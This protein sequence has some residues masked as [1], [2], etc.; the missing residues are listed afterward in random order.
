MSLFILNVLTHTPPWVW[1]LLTVLIALGLRQAR[2]HSVTVQRVLLQ[3]LILGTLSLAAASSSFGLHWSVQPAWLLGAALGWAL[4]RRLGLPRRVQPL[5]GGRYLIGGSWAPMLTILSIFVLR[6][7]AGAALAI[8]PTL[9]TEPGF[10][11]AASLLYGLPVGL[12]AARAAHVLGA[13]R[14]Q[15]ALQIA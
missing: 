12:I 6:Y 13:G 15:P 1:I 7:T 4:N 5:D 9:A 10:A 14:Q 8:V 3:P 11:A 2:D